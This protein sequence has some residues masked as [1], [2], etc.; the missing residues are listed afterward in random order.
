M[1][2]SIGTGI[3]FCVTAIF[4]DEKDHASQMEL[5]LERLEN[6]LDARG[7]DREKYDLEATWDYDL[8]QSAYIAVAKAIPRG[9]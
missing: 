8:V 3:G 4:H 2:K 7:E 5:C 6:E 9:Y 1:K